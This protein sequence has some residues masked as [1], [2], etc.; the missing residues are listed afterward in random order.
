MCYRKAAFF[1]FK[2]HNNLKKWSERLSEIKWQKK[3]ESS[4]I[5]KRLWGIV[6]NVLNVSDVWLAERT[7]E[8]RELFNVT[9]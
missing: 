7:R 8:V 9:R 4:C 3:M 5:F 6:E 1:T 2:I